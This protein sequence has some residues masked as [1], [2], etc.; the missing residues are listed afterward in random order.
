MRIAIEVN[1]EGR[2]L[3]HKL[4]MTQHGH[5]LFRAWLRDTIVDGDSDR[6]F[7][8]MTQVLSLV[9]DQHKLEVFDIYFE[10]IWIN[11]S[12]M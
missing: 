12:E 11:S 4:S 7:L 10:G 3:E 9:K 8:F 1:I 5:M 6:G 2:K